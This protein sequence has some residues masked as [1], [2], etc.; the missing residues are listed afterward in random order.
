MRISHV[1]AFALTILLLIVP[2]YGQTGILTVTG[3]ITDQQE[4]AITGASLTLTNN[5]TGAVR[6]AD[7]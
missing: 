7:V 1:G 5:A 3:T 6:T 4:R 2:S